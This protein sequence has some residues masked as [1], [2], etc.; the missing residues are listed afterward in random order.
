MF[1]FNLISTYVMNCLWGGGVH[2][3]KVPYTFLSLGT[4]PKTEYITYLN[5]V[6]FVGIFPVANCTSHQHLI[7]LIK[8][9]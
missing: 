9:L 4:Q 2:A 8:V 7:L 6:L 5:V 1:L 3:E